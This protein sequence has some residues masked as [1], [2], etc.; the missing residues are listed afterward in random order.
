M[1]G[2]RGVDDQAKKKCSS[3]THKPLTWSRAA[4]VMLTA[5]VAVIH[6][7]TATLLLTSVTSTE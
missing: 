5:A 6:N 2:K 1:I 4:T 7:F 3:R